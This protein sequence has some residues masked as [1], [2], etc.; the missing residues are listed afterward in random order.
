MH[1]VNLI[2]TIERKKKVGINSYNKHTMGNAKEKRINY[3]EKKNP[4]VKIIRLVNQYHSID[5]IEYATKEEKEWAKQRLY[6]QIM[7]VLNHC[8]SDIRGQIKASIRNKDIW[9][10]TRD[11][12]S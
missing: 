3:E 6:K 8:S 11:S 1:W 10:M 5:L 4:I 2:I 7:G 9:E 12:L